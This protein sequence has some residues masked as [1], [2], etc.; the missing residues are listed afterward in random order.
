[1]AKSNSYVFSVAA[2]FSLRFA[3]YLSPYG[4]NKIFLVYSTPLPQF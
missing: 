4:V 1:M 3:G 2:G